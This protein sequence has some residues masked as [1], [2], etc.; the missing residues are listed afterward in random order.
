[1]SGNAKMI[2]RSQR[3]VWHPCTQMKHHETL[4]LVPISGAEGVWLHD[5]E[6]RRILDAIGTCG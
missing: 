4:P 2:E 1:V 5:F 3:A 6:G